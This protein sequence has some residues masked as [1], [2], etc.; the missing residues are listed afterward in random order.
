MRSIRF[1]SL[2]LVLG[3]GI[4][5]APRVSAQP[6]IPS[7]T[8]IAIAGTGMGGFSGDGGPAISAM[9]NGHCRFGRRSCWHSSLLQQ[10]A[11][12]CSESRSQMAAQAALIVRESP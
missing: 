9:L 8:V 5:L 6:P 7:G 10:L 11:V 12:P 4:P 1:C 2:G 3:L